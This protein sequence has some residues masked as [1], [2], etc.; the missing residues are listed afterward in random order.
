M[1]SLT[2][3][4]QGFDGAEAVLEKKG[5]HEGPSLGCRPENIS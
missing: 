5:R 2:Q 4:T 1:D 3:L